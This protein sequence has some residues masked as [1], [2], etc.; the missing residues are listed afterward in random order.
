MSKQR[1]RPLQRSQRDR[2]QAQQESNWQPPHDDL[3]LCAAL[4]GPKEFCNHISQSS[5]RLSDMIR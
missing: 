3:L 1:V 5:E 2:L 4:G